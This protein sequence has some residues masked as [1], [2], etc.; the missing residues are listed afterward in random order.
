MIKTPIFLVGAERSGTTLLRL[1]LDHHPEIAFNSEF[2]YAIKFF[3]FNTL[4][5]YYGFLDQDRIFRSSNFIID[6]K[7]NPDELVNIWL[8]QKQGNK[9]YIGATV[10]HQFNR[11]I[12]I[13][14]D[15][16]FIHIVR[17]PRDV[18]LSVV[19]IGWAGNTWKGCERW[20][21]AEQTW[22]TLKINLKKEQYLEITYEDLILKTQEILSYVCGFIGVEYNSK[23]L[24]YP[25]YTTYKLP[26]NSMAYK[27]INMLKIFDI[28]LINIKVGKELILANNYLW[29]ENSININWFYK[30]YLEIE[31]KI[32]CF[33]FRINR[34]GFKLLL[35]YYIARKLALK[36]W[37]EQLNLQIHDIEDQYLV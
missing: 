35:K 23:M 17:D 34:F 4:Q 25:E 29:S 26:D 24:S 32:L 11:L 6:R 1:M 9:K 18:A 20:I 33:K 19:Q 31:N 13:W 30:L 16:K 37:A 8:K 28:N 36:K 12:K 27:W 3:D 15:A 22:N 21:T 7:C 2:D 5:E 14:P 10:H